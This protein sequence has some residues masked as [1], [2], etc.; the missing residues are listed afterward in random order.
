M[1]KKKQSFLCSECGDTFPKWFGKCPSCDEFG[2]VKEFRESKV[3]GGEKLDQGV[4]LSSKEKTSHTAKERFMSNIG[5]V[6]RV[7]GGGFFPGSVILFGGHPGIGKS[8]LALQTFL[9]LPKEHNSLYFSGEESVEQILHRV[10][11]VNPH[12]KKTKNELISSEVQGKDEKR[13]KPYDPSTASSIADFDEEICRN[14]SIFATNSLEDI[15]ATIEKSKPAL[16]V[17]DSIQMIGSENSSFGSVS[18]IKENAEILV[19]TAKACGT[20]ILIIG[21]VTKND[22]LAGPKVLEHVVDCVLYL[23]G[24]ANSEIRIL[25]AQK[26]RFGS[27]QE[28]GVF[29]MQNNGLVELQNPSEYFL[30]ERAENS[31]G[32]AI[33]VIREGARKFLLEIQVLTVKTNFGIPRRTAGGISLQKFHLLCAVVSKF[34]PFNMENFDG[35]LSVVGGFKIAE[36]AAD[37]AICAAIL[38]SRAG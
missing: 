38:S 26:N 5:E 15:V 23:E 16:A 10:E 22:E 32:S 30:A 4:D 19:R 7:L 20:A 24:D 9:N 11:R 27:T 8:T 25:R 12:N 28:I 13:S 36:P 3:S 6:D 33:S 2:T 31:S 18:Q 29:D 21:H 34:T 17:I 35:Y 1:S 14:Q 37:L